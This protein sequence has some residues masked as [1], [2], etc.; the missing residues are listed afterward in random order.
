M[1]T[2]ELADQEKYEEYQPPKKQGRKNKAEASK[3]SKESHMTRR[4]PQPETSE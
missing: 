2:D 3:L 1:K 4:R